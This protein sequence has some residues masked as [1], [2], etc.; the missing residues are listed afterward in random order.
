MDIV[1]HAYVCDR[2]NRA[3]RVTPFFFNPRGRSLMMDLRNFFQRTGEPSP[4]RHKRASPEPTE[5]CSSQSLSLSYTN[6]REQP[7]TI[8]SMLSAAVDACTTS[9]GASSSSGRLRQAPTFRHEWLKGR[10]HWLRF[11]HG[12]GMFC[13][14]CIKYDKRPF[15]RETWNTIPCTRYRLQSITSHE[16]TVTHCDS[17]KLELAATATPAIS[18]A[19]QLP[20]V[21]AR[22]ME[23]AFSCLY[24]LA[25]QRIPHTTNFEPLLDLLSLLGLSVYTCACT[26]A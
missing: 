24:F 22:G 12:K 7:G 8:A 23:Q 5:S 16:G 18:Q 9:P 25:K 1:L 14:L 2:A 21:P 26:R 20:E 17:V 6:T 11:V 15:N 10:E 13:E 19:I 3:Y 4:K